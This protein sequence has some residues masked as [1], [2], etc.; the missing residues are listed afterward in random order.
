M[1]L[2]AHPPRRHELPRWALVV[3]AS[4]GLVVRLWLLSS[5]LGVLD[6]DEAVGGLIAR[7]FL[8]G[9]IS[10]FLWGNAWGGTLEAVLTA[11]IF[12]LVGSS[13]TAMK[14]VMVGFYAAGCLLT[15]RVGR[16]LV[17]ESTARFAASLLWIFP[18]SLVLLSIKARLYYGSA[19]VIALGIVLIALRLK[20]EPRA[21]DVA[22]VGLLL[23]LGLWTAPFIFYVAVPIGLW[24]LWQRRQL[25]RQVPL[26]LT[27]FLLGALPW[28]GFNLR[29]GFPSLSEPPIPVESA[30]LERLAGFFTRLLPTLLGLRL[31]SSGEW[32]LGIVG[33]LLYLAALIGLVWFAWLSFRRRSRLSPLLVILAAYPFLFAVPQ[34]SFYVNEPRYGL[35]LAPVVTLLLASALWSWIKPL[36]LQLTVLGLC[37]LAT[38]ASTL[39]V[40]D[41]TRRFPLNHDIAAAPLA[42]LVEELEDQD[43]ETLYADYWIAYRLT[44]ETEEEVIASPIDFVR[45]PPY[46]TIVEQVAE[47]SNETTYVV[48]EGAPKDNALQTSLDQ[49]N[50]AHERVIAGDFAVY[51]VEA[52][53]PNETLEA[54]QF[55]P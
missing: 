54:V 26:T 18:G 2:T 31:T 35:L 15:W 46:E 16:R 39:A 41:F 42:P 23:G 3:A 52:F 19:M 55:I 30:Y 4:V 13:V 47:W 34:S 1:G 17:D 7:H 43:V 24:L 12:A 37:T 21:V 29:N 11:G 50:L 6:S 44:F 40:I 49:R 36:G 5:P 28:I 20:E 14:L 33:Q 38:V 25:W 48:H 45:Y 53:L 27:G 51:Y 22:G 32:V 8:D 9:E 10:V